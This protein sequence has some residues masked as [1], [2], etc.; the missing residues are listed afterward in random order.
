VYRIVQI[1]ILVPD[2]MLNTFQSSNNV[3]DPNIGRSLLMNHKLQPVSNISLDQ[4]NK[5]ED[6]VVLENA[7]P[8]IFLLKDDVEI[9][10]RNKPSHHHYKSLD[11]YNKHF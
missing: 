3:Q 9:H 6:S 8:H 11:N 2:A 4:M 1:L 7:R 5:W 10:H